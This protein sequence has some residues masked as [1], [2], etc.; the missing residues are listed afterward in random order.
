MQSADICKLEFWKAI[1]I[2][3]FENTC[4]LTYSYF[5][6]FESISLM[7]S[8]DLSNLECLR[9]NGNKLSR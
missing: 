1:K 7:N 9:L 8:E 3:N 6:G 2:L 5:P 4:N